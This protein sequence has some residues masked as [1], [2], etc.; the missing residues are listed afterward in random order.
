MKLLP[1]MLFTLML[2]AMAIPAGAAV[3][4]QYSYITVTD[5]IIQ[6]HDDDAVID[7]NYSIDP[8][9]ELLVHFLGKSDLKWKLGTITG[10][11]KARYQVIGMDHATIHVSGASQNYGGGSYWFPDHTFGID[12][13]EITVISPQADRYY[14]MTQT[15]P[16]MGY[17]GTK[18][19][20]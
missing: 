6:L 20:A 9:I 7:L 18:N 5:C 16:G 13:P 11:P 1:G 19:K 12:I 2:I 14:N 15:V 3:P 8:G 4:N 10:Y 17:F